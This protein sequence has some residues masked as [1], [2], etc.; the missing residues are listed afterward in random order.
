M[1]DLYEKYFKNQ[2]SYLEFLFCMYC[3]EF[4]F[5]F[6]SAVRN[7]IKEKKNENDFMGLTHADLQ[8]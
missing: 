2:L 5:K 7:G 6:V 1:N 4:G 8:Q 3:L